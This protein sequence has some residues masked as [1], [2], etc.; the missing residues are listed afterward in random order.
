MGARWNDES[1]AVWVCGCM[2]FICTPS[3]R[4]AGSCAPCLLLVLSLLFPTLTPAVGQQ[5]SVHLSVDSD[6]VA[7]EEQ[8]TMTVTLIGLSGGNV[9]LAGLSNFDV[10][11][12]SRGSSFNIVNGQV[13]SSQEEHYQLRPKRTGTFTLG[14]ATVREGGRAYRSQSVQVTVVSSRGRRTA[15]PSG[16]PLLPL[17]GED[18]TGTA[19]GDVMAKLT[20]EPKRVFVNQQITLTFLLYYR[21]NLSDAN[22]SPPQT[23]GFIV[24]KL[25]QPSGTR[26][27]INGQP[28]VVERVPI[29]LFAVKPGK[30]TLGPA[31]LT[32]S[33]GFWGEPQTLKTN[34]VAL[35]VT[36]LPQSGRPAN[37]TGAVGSFRLEA[38]LD[39]AQVKR[40]EAVALKAT[41]NGVG[42]VSSVHQLV[43][44]QPAGFRLFES[45]QKE[46]P[47]NQGTT[48]TGVKTFE[49]VL[50]PSKEGSVVLGSVSLPMFD[51]S[52]GR[53]V[54]ARSGA[55]SL[56]VL[57]GQATSSVDTLPGGAGPQQVRLLREDIRYIKGDRSSLATK[58]GPLWREP[59]YV[60][61]HLLPLVLVVGAS[62]WRRRTDRLA[63][64]EALQRLLRGSQA[65][66]K[67]LHEAEVRSKSGSGE[68]FYTALS[69]ALTE[70]LAARL[71]VPVVALSADTAAEHLKAAP[72]P[73]SATVSVTECLRAAELVRFAPA[74]PDREAMQRHL[75]LA[76]EAIESLESVFHRAR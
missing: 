45:S 17:P 60:A 32:F 68:E 22:Y 62:V 72:A 30:F 67:W 21:I 34:T 65:A 71:D 70:Y 10:V 24:H 6:Q 43:V 1:L 12:T 52:S 3:H 28:Y 9:Q 13:S 25:P 53:Y 54:V 19:P 35:Q 57:P 37:F 59:W 15:P 66:R 48:V 42:N 5:S 76:R 31:S 18:M 69:R 44:P 74:A 50:V 2:E 29:A 33:S 4:R 58:T 64:D 8:F 14:P 40:G 41:V 16:A 61:L 56:T 11:G 27:T 26:A 36:D 55:L 49:Y 73:E 51:P 38:R 47:A 39:K 46:S 23:T 75:R 20:A 63:G 7:L